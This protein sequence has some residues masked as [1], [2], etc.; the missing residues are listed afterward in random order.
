MKTTC[1]YC[2]KTEDSDLLYWVHDKEGYWYHIECFYQNQFRFIDK[3]P[4][5]SDGDMTKIKTGIFGG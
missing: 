3:T 1:M 5:V 2:N 4:V